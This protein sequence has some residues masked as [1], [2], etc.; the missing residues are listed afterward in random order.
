MKAQEILEA[1]NGE[2][3]YLDSK[4]S[5]EKEYEYGFAS[6]LMSDAL[7]LIQS[8]ETK[9]V[10]ITGLANIQS[11]NTAD[12]LDISLVIIVRGKQL[13]ENVIS[14]AQNHNISVFKS[15]CSMYE[16]CG[17]LFEKGLGSIDVNC[18]S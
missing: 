11:I 8:D 1:I 12:M 18:L 5:L 3:L 13:E 15:N 2:I 7:A 9:T 6:D 16:V 17:L 4:E 14:H 10:L